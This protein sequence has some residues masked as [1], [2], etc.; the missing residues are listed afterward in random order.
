MKQAQTVTAA[1][2]ASVTDTK[3]KLTALKE[4]YSS[5]D[6]ISKSQCT[7]LRQ[8]FK[9]QEQAEID[10]TASFS[11]HKDHLVCAVLLLLIKT[12]S[13]TYKANEF[14]KQLLEQPAT[15]TKSNKQSRTGGSSSSKSGNSIK[16]A[17]LSNSRHNEGAC[18][19]ATTTAATATATAATAA[20]RSTDSSDETCDTA[21]SS[22]HH[23]NAD[24][25]HDVSA[26]GATA[27]SSA[28]T[29]TNSA[30]GSSG[31][32]KRK[33]HVV[34]GRDRTSVLS[35]ARNRKVTRTSFNI[36]TQQYCTSIISSSNSSC[37]SCSSSSRCG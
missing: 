15:A 17:V 24:D 35:G 36:T 28:Q 14:Y 13:N 19:G 12:G 5:S 29:A 11:L 31:S 16:A 27:S 6:S 18:S 22:P 25:T 37:N 33:A 7:E 1:N 21:A 26:T 2:L 23:S 10:E 4:L 32:G 20:G 8:T 30:A 9:P 34:A 3:D